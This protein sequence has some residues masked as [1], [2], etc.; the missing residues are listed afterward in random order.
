MILPLAATMAALTA[1]DILV[2]WRG[3]RKHGGS[4][5]LREDEL[6]AQAGAALAFDDCVPPH[7]TEGASVVRVRSSA[8]SSA[9]LA[10]AA[11]RCMLVRSAHRVLAHGPD[12]ASVAALAAALPAAALPPPESSWSLRMRVYEVGAKWGQRRSPAPGDEAAAVADFSGLISRIQGPVRL[13]KPDVGLF[14]L[15]G[16]GMAY[17]GTGKSVLTQQLCLGLNERCKILEKHRLRIRPY[18]STT[19]MEPE[20]ALL[21]ASLALVGAGAR[22]LDPMA[23]SGGILVAAAELGAAEIVGI[24]IDHDALQ[25]EGV[26]RNLDAYDLGARFSPLWGDASDPA[27]PAAAVA[28]LSDGA[29]FDAVVCDP[30]YVCC[31]AP[32]APAPRRRLTRPAGTACGRRARPRTRRPRSSTWPPRSCGSAGGWRSGG[33]RAWRR[34]RPR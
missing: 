28:A 16:Q 25:A 18:L 29:M 23:G 1:G 22:V 11:G 19:T 2:V 32:A 5:R 12:R 8:V 14:L 26:R 7:A 9:A 34:P 27:L 3:G 17:A 21:T 20:A 4:V 10:E 6:A 31:A 33:R 13:G 24:E 15:E 30:P